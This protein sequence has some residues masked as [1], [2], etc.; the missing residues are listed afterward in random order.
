MT[1]DL[2]IFTAAVRRAKM[3][4]EEIVKRDGVGEDLMPCLELWIDAKPWMTV[5]MSGDGVDHAPV[6]AA[7]LAFSRCDL[8]VLVTEGY[9][10]PS[11]DS[12]DTL[13]RGE[14]AERFA[15]GDPAVVEGLVLA[16]FPIQGPT[17][18]TAV[19]YHYDGRSVVWGDERQAD[20]ASGRLEDA[21]RLGY[22]ERVADA[23]QVEH[24]ELAASLVTLPGV[25]AV[26]LFVEKPAPRNAPCP[27][28]SGRK[29]KHCDHGT[30]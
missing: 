17:T 3:M 8:A 6:I 30:N 7:A 19:A 4:K 16:M 23:E 1:A 5:H 20:A 25:D 28:G 22:A 27:C 24:R 18:L 2:D 12:G 11:C 21:A 14:L 15:A 9:T 10:V 29:A 13:R 26:G